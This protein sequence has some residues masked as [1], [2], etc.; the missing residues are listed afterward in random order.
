MSTAA[1][2]VQ[3]RG[4]SNAKLTKV[5]PKSLPHRSRGERERRCSNELLMPQ[6]RTVATDRQPGPNAVMVVTFY[7]LRNRWDRAKWRSAN[8]PV[9]PKTMVSVKHLTFANM[10]NTNT[11]GSARPLAA[12]CTRELDLI[13]KLFHFCTHSSEL[14]FSFRGVLVG[15]WCVCVC[16]PVVGDDS[17]RTAPL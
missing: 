17:D 15:C 9:G 3:R 1:P 11:K 2:P 6:V 4:N 16:A 5:E 13:G 12:A 14:L 7:G 8:T 10:H